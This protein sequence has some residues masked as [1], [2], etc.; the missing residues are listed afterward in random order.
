MQP[1]LSMRLLEAWEHGRAQHP[2]RRALTMLQVARPEASVLELAAMS[3][4]AR[5][6]AL[7]ELR[8]QLFGPQFQ[9]V[10]TCPE[11]AE[12]LDLTFSTGNVPGAGHAAPAGE[13]HF[14]HQGKTVA[15]RMPTTADLA[16]AASA[17]NRAEALLA[18]CA[19]EAPKSAWA[20]IQNHMAEWDPMAQVWMELSCPSCRHQWR[21]VFDIAGYL[22]IE[23]GDRAKQLLREVDGLARAYGWGER[24]ILALSS[25][26]RRAYLSLATGG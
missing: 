22:W 1:N 13:F 7:L 20:E 26:R 16:E 12:C 6:R 5:D 4:G 15:V 17:E 25:Q 3:I 10:A 21:A 19:P 8:E 2:L 24:E 18:R 14:A 11:C 23:L 9:S